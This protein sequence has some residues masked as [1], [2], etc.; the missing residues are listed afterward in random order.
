MKEHNIYLDTY[1]TT[2]L[3]RELFSSG[4]APSTQVYPLNISSSP[5]H[6]W[7]ID[8]EASYNMAKDKAMFSTL[9]DCHTKNTYVGD[10]RSLS[11]VGSR[12]VHMDNGQF[13]YVLCAPTLS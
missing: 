2:Y 9:N 7:L 5:S 3:R 4:Y 6:V 11:V 8:Y 1:L 13:K 12:I 10:D